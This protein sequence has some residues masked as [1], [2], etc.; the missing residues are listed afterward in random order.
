MFDFRYHALS[1]AAV[2]IALALGL[3]LGVAIGDAGL[4]SSAEQ[5]VRDSLRSQLRDARGQASVQHDQLAF[6]GQYESDVY[7][8]LVGGRLAGKRIGL[9]FIGEPTDAVN[10]LVRQSLESTGASLVLVAV[11]RDPP[12]LPSLAGHAGPGRYATL[13]SDPALVRPFGVRVGRQ[14]V[15][16]GRLLQ[17][18]KGNLLSSFNGSLEPLNA[19]VVMR[20]RG[21]LSAAETRIADPFDEGLA[22]GLVSPGSPVV[23]VELGSTNPSQVSWYKG[24]RLSSVDNLDD[25][26]GRTALVYAL[27]GAQGSYGTKATAEALLPQGPPPAGPTAQVAT[28]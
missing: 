28:R 16:G 22:A 1:L 15:V 9:I 25:I 12:D 26:A 19:V 24:L 27:A 21:S 11:V 5:N 8:Q 2:L 20:N 10:S 23:G 6:R 14:L 7:P 4:V 3:L 18:V 17:R 13:A